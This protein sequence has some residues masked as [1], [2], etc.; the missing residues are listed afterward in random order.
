MRK[1]YKKYIHWVLGGLLVSFL[2]TV[3]FF[4]MLYRVP[5]GHAEG[6][7]T[8]DIPPGSPLSAI[9]D[10]LLKHRIIEDEAAFEFALR[11]R[12]LET[13]LQPGIF[14]IPQGASYQ[15]LIRILSSQRPEVLNVTVIEGLQ[16]R[17]IA[18][19]LAGKFRFEARDFSALV[20]DSVFA[21]KLGVP[22]P[23]LEGF[24]FPETYRFF[25]NE[26]PRSIAQKMVQQFHTVVP[27]SF[28]TRAE[29]LGWT[30]WEAVT[31][32]SIIE[33]EAVHDS[34]RDEIASVYHNRLDQGMRLQADPT[35]QYII[36]DG[37]RRLWQKD[38]EI[39]SPYNTYRNAGLPP[40][41]INNPGLSSIRAALYPAETGYLYF[42]ASGDGYHTFSRTNREHIN[43]K[44]KLQRLRQQVSIE[45][46]NQEDES[47]K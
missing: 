42:V 3:I 27:D 1:S 46:G 18:D 41:P 11:L 6:T 37:P 12:G 38:L 45:E 29:E 17:E 16:S 13:S 20:N 34:E 30:M 23:S 19:L 9:S 32:A 14:Q 44:R 47:S 39:E 31:L 8:I 40:G 21:R 35:I 33:G 4:D 25:L 2:S 5:R 7:S 22:G 15:T 36:E 43:A 28:Y 24:L 10:S 26:S